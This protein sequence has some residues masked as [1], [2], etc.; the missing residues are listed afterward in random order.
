MSTI[1]QATVSVLISPELLKDLGEW[2][3]PVQVKIEKRPDGTYEM[4]ARTRE[5]GS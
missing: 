3:A 2:S 5:V 1:E 4:I